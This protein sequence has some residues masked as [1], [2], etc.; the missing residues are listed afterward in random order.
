MLGGSDYN[1]NTIW[2]PAGIPTAYIQ[3]DRGR[4]RPAVGHIFRA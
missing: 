3:F 2:L 4:G 1:E